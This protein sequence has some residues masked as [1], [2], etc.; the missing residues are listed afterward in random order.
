MSGNSFVEREAKLAVPVDFRIGDLEGLGE[1]VAAGGSDASRF[2]TVYWD[3]PDLRLARWGTALRHRAGEGWTVKLPGVASSATDGGALVRSEHHFDGTSAHP[4]DG[5]LGLLR[6]YVRRD[7]LVPVA[8]M[9]TWRQS[10]A[11]LGDAGRRLGEIDD[12]LVSVY[13]GRRTSTRF[14]EIE[15]EV[16]EGA[17]ADLLAAVVDRLRAGGAGAPDPTPKLVRA[18]GRRATEAP[19]VSAGRLGRRATAG[20]VAR[21]ALAASVAR[22][23]RHDP[24]VRLG[25]DPEDVHQARVAT[26]RL[27]SDLRTFS[28]AVFQEDWAESLRGEL[29]W[30][31]GELGAG[32]DAEVLRDRLAGGADELA[33]EDS[34]RAA[35]LLTAL[36]GE[37]RDARAKLRAA[38]QE[39]RYVDL[40]ERLIEGARAPKFAAGAAA[41][42][43][44]VLPDLCAGP[45]KKLRTM[46]ERLLASPSATDDEL[47][48]LRIRAKRCRYAAEAAAPVIGRPAAAFARAVAALQGVLGELHD[49]VVLSDWLRRHATAADAF[50]AGEL[51]CQERFVAARAR[52]QWPSVWKQISRKQLTSWM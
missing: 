44:K 38:M 48:Q 27:R 14:H 31:G 18:L 49:A 6:A 34:P 28:G 50:V 23:L 41:P 12:D 21:V 46:A 2:V 30:V 17:P 3:T 15:V 40:I 43:R 33:P 11:L 20:E 5:A 36:D 47:H 25:Q 7:R 22:L 45:W 26:R 1:G 4:P 35:A 8:R 32:R 52:E 19:E 10:I 51:V 39:E 13:D 9:R 29:R 16:A 37:V 42:A 24:G